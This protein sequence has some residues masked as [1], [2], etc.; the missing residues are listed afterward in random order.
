MR[1]RLR[2]QMNLGTV[3]GMVALFVALGGP[4]Y[5]GNTIGKALS[6]KDADRV[7]KLHASKAPKPG[8]LLALDKKG[9]FPVSVLPLTEGPQ[10]PAGPAGE[11]GAR[12]E[13]GPIGPIGP[14][15]PQGD[16]GPAGPA[17]SPDGP[18]QVIS[19]AIQADGSGSGLDAD[20]VDGVDSRDLAKG[21]SST[22]SKKMT[23]TTAYP[24]DQLVLRN[25]NGNHL[26]TIAA[27][28]EGGISF[29][30]DSSA[31]DQVWWRTGSGSYNRLVDWNQGLALRGNSTAADLLEVV[32]L[33]L[34]RGDMTVASIGVMP[35]GIGGTR[36]VVQA[37]IDDTVYN[38]N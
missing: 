2:T 7:D 31:A 12:G 22:I 6:A 37:T 8:T 5:A 9:K 1:T 10:G 3:L 24:S 36:L 34:N 23:L 11:A 15:G 19:K 32:I 29:W 25:R 35:Y 14:A 21:S 16:R 20:S 4:S 28:R 33:D 27:T 13:A 18:Q 38:G 17:G 26:G 30:N